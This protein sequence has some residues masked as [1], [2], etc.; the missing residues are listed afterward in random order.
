MHIGIKKILKI[1]H[2]E[3]VNFTYHSERALSGIFKNYIN[4]NMI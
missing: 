4:V 3:T 1:V 2:S